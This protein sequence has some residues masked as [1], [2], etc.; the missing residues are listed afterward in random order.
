MNGA[1]IFGAAG[2]FGVGALLVALASLVAS[3]VLAVARGMGN[4]VPAAL[5]LTTPA[6]A[7]TIGA[8][9]AA[10][11]AQAAAAE[12]AAAAPAD[13]LLLARSG[14]PD[15]ASTLVVT[16]YCGGASLLLAAGAV[17]IGHV[18]GRV[19]TERT[20]ERQRQWVCARVLLATTLAGGVCGVIAGNALA[21]DLVAWSQTDLLPTTLLDP[22]RLAGL[23][24]MALAAAL[25]FAVT[26]PSWREL[27][28]RRSLVGLALCLMLLAGAGGAEAVAAVERSRLER[29]LR[30]PPVADVLPEDPLAA[31]P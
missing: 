24:L 18:V 25:T 26:V 17:F 28:K 3:G 31:P 2:G 6:L 13:Q 14:W 30:A 4:W 8:F 21:R 10:E 19:Q 29:V 9:G 15:V 23:A 5:W 22:L 12:L 1:D 20:P 11:A 27:V 7:W 16:R